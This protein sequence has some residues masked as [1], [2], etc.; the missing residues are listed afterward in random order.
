MATLDSTSTLAQI[1]A[2]WKDNASYA[3]DN[4]TA[5]AR[6]FETACRFLIEALPAQSGR[7][8]TALQFDKQSMREE[9]TQ[10]R[11]WIAVRGA[12]AGGSGTS[13]RRLSFND[14]RS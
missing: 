8:G 14:F 10:V 2:S 13:T 6:A 11:K 7:N 3:E 4:S 9:L 1:R 5:K 12:S